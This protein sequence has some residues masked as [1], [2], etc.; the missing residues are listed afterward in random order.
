MGARFRLKASVDI[1]ALNPQARVIA[2]ALKDYGL[3][4]ADNGSAFFMTGA[5]YSPDA[6]NNFSLTWND[7]DIQ[8]TLHGLKSLWFT[9]FEVVD[10]TPAVTNVSPTQGAAGASVT[11]S[12]RNFSGAA[13]R[14]SVWFGSNQVSAAVT[15]DAHLTAIAPSGAGPVDVRVQSFL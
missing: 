1:S 9:N 7:N 8:D 10:L 12:G 11:I 3:I 2:Q 15:D 13:G 5:S 6:N 4:V 14:L